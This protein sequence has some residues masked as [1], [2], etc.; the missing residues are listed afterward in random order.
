VIIQISLQLFQP[1]ALGT[2]YDLTVDLN[3][4][5]N[6]T[7]GAMAWIDWNQRWGFLIQEKRLFLGIQ[8]IIAMVTA[9][10]I[11]TYFNHGTEGSTRMRISAKWKPSNTSPAPTS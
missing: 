10:A 4:A 11:H 7:I 2:S 6:Y 9:I 8:I 5:G 3:T 1:P